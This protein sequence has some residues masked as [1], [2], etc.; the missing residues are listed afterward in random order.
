MI[1]LIICSREEKLLIQVRETIA[2]TIGLPHEIIAIDN[3]AGKHSI[4]EAYNQ[5]IALSKYDVLCFMHEDISF[6]TPNWGQVVLDTFAAHPKLGLLGVAGST[7]KPLVPSGWSHGL[8]TQRTTFMHLVQHYKQ[9]GSELFHNNPTGKPFAKVVS[10]DGVWFCTTKAVVSQ[11]KFD[12][13]TFKGFHC[14][15]VDFSL[16]VGQRFEVGVTFDILIHH[17]SEGSLNDSWFTETLKLHKKW[18]ATLPINLAGLSPKLRAQEEYG[19]FQAILPRLIGKRKFVLALFRELWQANVVS[20]VGI[21]KYVR[22]NL[23]LI[24][25]SL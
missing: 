1:S 8:A 13:A 22:M 17:F 11:I 6:D 12:A 2:K 18:R 16:S 10:V 15:D 21:K 14:Y 19:A 3:S 23:L 9:G 20:L 5:G 25:K 4:F 24:K 7:Y